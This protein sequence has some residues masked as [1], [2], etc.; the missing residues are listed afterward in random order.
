MLIS[1]E[2]RIPYQPGFVERDEAWSVALLSRDGVAVQGNEA[3]R[4]LILIIYDC[5]CIQTV[6]MDNTS[7]P[8]AF[9]VGYSLANDV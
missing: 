4:E 5:P 9:H 7:I 2:F 6:C 1:P 3:G 8:P